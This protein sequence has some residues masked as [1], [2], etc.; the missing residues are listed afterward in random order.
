MA[1]QDG[2]CELEIPIAKNIPDKFVCGGGGIVDTVRF[3]RFRDF[4]KGF[5]GLGNDPAVER[6]N[7]LTRVEHRVKHAAVH[8]GETDRIPKFCAKVPVTF[9]ALRR[10]LYVA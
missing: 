4:S 5:G 6:E 7:C 2:L 1:L 9:D 3:D 10:E 8:F